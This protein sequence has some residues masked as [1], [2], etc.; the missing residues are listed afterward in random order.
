MN[1][2]GN[3]IGV[4]VPAICLSADTVLMLGECY[5]NDRDSGDP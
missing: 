2:A 1:P 3:I 5:P 4:V